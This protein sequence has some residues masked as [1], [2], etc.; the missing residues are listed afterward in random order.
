[1]PVVEQRRQV[2]L[3]RRKRPGMKARRRESE[4]ASKDAVTDSTA[5]CTWQREWDELMHEVEVLV[6]GRARE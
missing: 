2:G 1:M 3:R 5:L 4:L 6:F